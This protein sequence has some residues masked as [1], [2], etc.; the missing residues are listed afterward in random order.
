MRAQ[1][2]I[3]ELDAVSA[4]SILVGASASGVGV[5]H[6][7]DGLFAVRVPIGASNP[8]V[9]QAVHAMLAVD[10]GLPPMPQRNHAAAEVPVGTE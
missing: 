6:V 9:F 10:C 3:G 4:N 8:A 1:S 5:A 2:T 7:E